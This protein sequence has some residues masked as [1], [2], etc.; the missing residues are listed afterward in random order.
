M[1]SNYNCLLI[2][3]DIRWLSRGKL[4]SR[5]FELRA[6]IC[7]FFKNEISIA[8]NQKNRMKMQ[9]FYDCFNNELWC[10]KL[11]YIEHIFA[12]LNSLNTS[13]QG[14]NENILTSTDKLI[15]FD[16]KLCLWIKKLDE[17]NFAMFPNI[18]EQMRIFLAPLV[19][20]HL[21]LLQKAMKKYFPS[22]TSETYDW[23]RNP[24]T[25]DTSNWNLCLEEEEELIS[26]SSDRTLK[27]KHSEFH[28]DRFWIS[29]RGQY[30]KLS[31]R[32]INILLQFSTSYL[33]ELG[34]STLTNM[35]NKKRSRLENVEDELRVALSEIRP[36]IAEITKHR[37]SHISH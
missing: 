27:I 25:N 33:C 31:K 20:I 17:N 6:E 26:L 34:F 10:A 30:P 36:D 4:L 28:L 5:V 2:H 23:I 24:F 13:L 14:R 3:N 19:K 35:K 11:A 7:T 18:P 37:Q 15:A 16:K 9:N 8:G 1:E 29:V 22:I 32:A 21:D 12:H